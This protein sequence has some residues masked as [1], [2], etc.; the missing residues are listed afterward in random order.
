M[1]GISLVALQFLTIAA[2][3]WPGGG[4][5]G[6]LALA[7]ISLGIALGAWAL[8]SNRP[9]NFNIRPD[10]K[11]GGT[12]IMHGAYR[13]VRHPMYVALLVGGAGLALRDPVVWRVLAY[14]VL[15]I[16]LNVKARVEERAMRER[17]E[18]YAAYCARTPRFIPFVRTH[19]PDA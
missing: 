9:G 8:A 10:P 7:L 6:V 5:P 1:L 2:L 11:A 15:V 16:V 12:L 17:H 14:A 19:P 13:Y 4:R 3:L 18:G